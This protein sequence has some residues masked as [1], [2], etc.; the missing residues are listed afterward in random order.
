MKRK[1]SASDPAAL[2]SEIAAL[3]KATL[4]DLKSRWRALCGTEPPSR[5]SRELL[6][7]AIAYRLQEQT[8]G[9]LKP[10]TRRLLERIGNGSLPSQT[11]AA[12]RRK[13]GAGTVL[14]RE[15]HGT[16][17][18]ATVLDDGVVYRGR[19]YQSLSEVA[20]AITGTRWSGP[21]FFGLRGRG[22]EASNG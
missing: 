11:P 16:N 19:R 2:T 21:L 10:S 1:I 20:R 3:A 6:T 7:R 17:H 14:I 8:Y 9:G 5:I 13:T 12:S 15:W 22:K 4:A 18:R